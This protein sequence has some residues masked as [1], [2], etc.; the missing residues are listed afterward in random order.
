MSLQYPLP[1]AL[2]IVIRS[3]K[4]WAFYGYT[5]ENGRIEIQLP[6]GKYDIWVFKEKY[7][8]HHQVE[9][10]DRDKVKTI[11][12]E[13]KVFTEYIVDVNYLATYFPWETM[14]AFL[15]VITERPHYWQEMKELEDEIL[16]QATPKI[17]NL[18]IY[19]MYTWVQRPV[20]E[21]EIYYEL[22]FG[23]LAQSVDPAEEL[24]TSVTI[25]QTS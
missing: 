9:V 12:L 4:R 14:E 13:K 18:Y 21:Q 15:K 6:P 17:I 11:V 22:I 2:V 7:S 5:D 25:E 10:I 20:I 3:D 19:F 23:G 8:L 16:E 1:N 24:T